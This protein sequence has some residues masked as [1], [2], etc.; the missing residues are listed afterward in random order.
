MFPKAPPPFIS[1]ALLKN[2]Q[3]NAANAK[4]AWEILDP[5]G[6]T[7]ARAEQSQELK[8]WGAESGFA[9]KQQVSTP[10]LW[11]PESPNLYKVIT[12]VT[13]GGK[14]VD[15]VE[16][17]F[18][19]RTLAFDPDKGFLLNGRH[20]EVKGTCNHQDH[21]G[22]G[23]A[24]PDALQYFRVRRLKDMGGN[25]IRTS[26]NAPTPELLEA[27]DR[28][29][30]LVMDENR[31]LGSDAA[32][33]ARLEAQVRRDRNHPSVF[34]WSLFNEENAARRRRRARVAPNPCSGWLIRWTRRAFAPR[35]PMRA[36][37]I[38]A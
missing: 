34:I 37:S 11:S 27:C 16:T 4:V 22:V 24:L 21:A 14:V 1:R 19:I 7:A 18:G 26:H 5:Q 25:A 30:L 31:L 2:A 9:G 35:R 33:M 6:K 12:T 28:L 38:K 8:P 36:M 13:S 17:E 10:A 3:T 20:Y 15:R 23:V 32:N 29:G